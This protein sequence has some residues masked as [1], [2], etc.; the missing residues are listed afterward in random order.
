MPLPKRSL[1]LDHYAVEAAGG[2]GSCLV[3]ASSTNVNSR[4]QYGEPNIDSDF[5]IGGLWNLSETIK[6]N[7]AKAGIQ[8]IHAGRQCLVKKEATWS[9]LLPERWIFQF[10]LVLWQRR[11]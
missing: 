3:E 5:A 11:N 7:G 4:L 9:C 8:L 6:M 1:L 2:V 10:S